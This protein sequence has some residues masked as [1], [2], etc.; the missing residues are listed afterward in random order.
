[1]NDHSRLMRRLAENQSEEGGQLT[2]FL[3][4]SFLTFYMGMWSGLGSENI[5]EFQKGV[6]THKIRRRR[7]KKKISKLFRE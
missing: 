7:K 4:I 1:M 3:F 6:A 2:I 5:L